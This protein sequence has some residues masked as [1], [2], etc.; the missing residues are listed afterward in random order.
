MN[1]I[2][3][4]HK[5]DLLRIFIS[6]LLFIAAIIVCG[7]FPGLHPLLQAAIYLVPYLA[8]GGEVLIGAVRSLFAG[9]LLDENF[10]MSAASVGAMCIGEYPEAVFIM[11]F[12]G[13]GE[14][15]EH[16][17]VGRSKRSIAKLMDIRPENAF[18]EV[19][20]ELV[21][22]APESVNVGDVIVIRPGDKIPLDGIIT[23]GCTSTDNSMLTG[24]SLPAVLGVGDAVISGCINID[25]MIK[26]R[27]TSAYENSTVVKILKLVEESSESKAKVHGVIKRFAKYYTPIVVAAAI[28]TAVIPPLFFSGV[29]SEWIRTGLT[30]LVASCPCAIIISVPLGYFCGMGCASRNGI[31]VKGAVY[32][33]TLSKVKTFVFDKTG[34]FTT[35][36]LSVSEIT[37]AAGFSGQSILSLAA[38]AEKG[39]TH[40]LA[41]AIAKKAAEEGISIPAAVSVR[42]IPGHGIAAEVDGSTV[43]VGNERLMAMHAVCMPTKEHEKTALHVAANGKYMGGIAFT[44]SVKRNAAG[45]IAS[46]KSLGVKKTVMLTG[47]SRVT[48]EAI[49]ASVGM[50]E[51]HCRLL[52]DEKV[53]H[54]ETLI[55]GSDGFVAYVGDGINDAPVL[56]RSDVGL[57]MGGLGS[58]AAIE[59]ADIVIMDDSIE[60]IPLAVRIA[61][62][63]AFIVFQNIVFS[64]LVKLAVMVL[65]LLGITG[66]WLAAFADVGVM[67]IAVLN[68]LRCFFV[69]KG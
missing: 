5:S 26:V 15:F 29:W 33:E 37:A 52:P 49:A 35:G 53:A 38:A 65:G 67:I 2:I 6:A 10:L 54:T 16:I 55:S 45:C 64:L 9:K 12:F 44:D 63:T 47:D 17:A 14:L 66:I 34:T 39:S 30:F 31:L 21:R 50:D 23:E 68:S 22:V 42:E 27:V 18:I 25:G 28:L 3:K 69:K 36:R 62:K 48:G 20:G 19:D 7:I 13:I 60:K 46:L 59:A 58:D 32:L 4:E 8:A 41:A 43:L 61:Q 11:L 40:P 51:A 24:E 56:A 1:S 57:A